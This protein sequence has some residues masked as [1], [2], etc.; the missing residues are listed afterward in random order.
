MRDYT[1]YIKLILILIFPM[2]IFGQIEY[3]ESWQLQDL[4]ENNI[5]EIVSAEFTLKKNG[6]LKDSTMIYQYWFDTIQNKL[7]GDYRMEWITTGGKLKNP[8]QWQYIEQFYDSFDRLTKDINRPREIIAKTEYGRTKV[9]ST[10]NILLYDYDKNGNRILEISENISKRYSVSKY[11]NDTS[12][13]ESREIKRYETIYN[14]ENKPVERFC[15]RSRDS[16]K[17]KNVEWVY[18]EKGQL[19]TWISFTRT[20]RFHTKRYYFYNEENRI[21]KQVDSTGWYINGEPTLQEIIDYN[22]LVDGTYKA[23]HQSNLFQEQSDKWSI[24][25]NSENMP[26]K[27]ESVYGAGHTTYL[28]S[29]KKLKMESN[30]D[31]NNKKTFDRILEYNDYG[32][33]QAE[34]YIYHESPKYS[35]VTKYYYK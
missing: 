30:F 24:T 15:Y 22:Y 6:K 14:Q 16:L 34:Y 2:E 25:Y 18:N 8:Y 21:I 20:G 23:I 19:T 29:E 12:F 3:S 4:K 1:T 33:L 28:Y 17:Y 32:L 11:T 7:Y 10:W 9:D 31:I 26:L 27:K 35:K 5:S 13:Y